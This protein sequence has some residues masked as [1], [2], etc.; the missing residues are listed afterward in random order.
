MHPS[1]KN[2][3]QKSWKSWYLSRLLN[4]DA[5]SDDDDRFWKDEKVKILNIL[6]KKKEPKFYALFIL[7]VCTTTTTTSPPPPPIYPPSLSIPLFPLAFFSDIFFPLL[8]QFLCS[9]LYSALLLT[10]DLFAFP[11]SLALGQLLYTA[12]LFVQWWQSLSRF[13]F[14]DWVLPHHNDLVCS[15]LLTYYEWGVGISRTTSHM[16]SSPTYHQQ[17]RWRCGRH[18]YTSRHHIAT[19]TKDIRGKDRFLRISPL[20]ITITHGND[21][22]FESLYY[23]ILPTH[24]HHCH[25]ISTNETT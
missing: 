21:D 25:V 15:L 11:T 3:P 14:W 16:F 2:K 20:Q 18:W 8:G 9:F 7:S 5:S 24:H 4:V 10:P 23:S 13:W 17:L 19:A 22:D 12:P 6:L 1:L